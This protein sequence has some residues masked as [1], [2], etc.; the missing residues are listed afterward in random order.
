MQEATKVHV[1]NFDASTTRTASVLIATATSATWLQAVR[2]DYDVT[3]IDQ[4]EQIADALFETRYQLM[5]LD[6]KLVMDE[7]S[8]QL[9]AEIKRRFPS[10]VLCILTDNLA[11]DYIDRLLDT[12]ASDVL[13][14][15]ID[16]E[17]LLRH[18]RVLQRQQAESQQAADHMQQMHLIGLMAREL[19]GTEHPEMLVLE[20]IKILCNNFDLSGVVI[21]IE[22]GDRHHIYAG[23]DE[24]SEPHEVFDSY[25][26]LHN[27]DPLNQVLISGSA[28][29]LNAL[30]RTPF[31]AP[32]PPLQA[33][34]SAVVVPLTYADRP[35]GALALLRDETGFSKADLVPFE[36]FA[37]HLAL[38]YHNISYYHMQEARSRSTRQVLKAWQRLSGH[39]ELDTVLQEMLT[40]IGE[41]P[42]VKHAGLWLFDPRT[43]D[44]RIIT[45]ATR[46]V[47]ADEIQ[48]AYDNGHLQDFLSDTRLSPRP[49]VIGRRTRDPL[50]KLGQLMENNQLL[51]VPIAG[52]IMM[53][54]LIVSS[55]GKHAFSVEET[56]LIEGLAHAASQT[57]ERNT[58]IEEIQL[59]AGRMNAIVSSIHDGVFFIGDNDLVVYCNPQFAELTSI[60][61]AAVVGKPAGNLFGKLADK[62]TTDRDDILHAIQDALD[63]LEAGEY[64][65]IVEVHIDTLNTDIAIEFTRVEQPS[66]G[67]ASRVG[68]V[69]RIHD[70]SDPTAAAHN[71]HEPLLDML[72]DYINLP[73]LQMRES[74]MTLAANHDR[75]RGYSRARLIQQ[76]ASR[77]E[78]AGTLWTHFMQLYDLRR[79]PAAIVRDVFQPHDALNSALMESADLRQIERPVDYHAQPPYTTIR[80]DERLF[81]QAI[82]NLLLG[83]SHLNSEGDVLDV[84][85]TRENGNCQIVIRDRDSVPAYLALPDV[86]AQ[87]QR[88][89]DDLDDS[90]LDYLHFFLAAETIET[91]GGT[92]DIDVHP[93]SG[94]QIEV[95]FAAAESGLEHPV[96]SAA[97]PRESSGASAKH[98]TP[99]RLR[100]AVLEASSRLLSSHYGYLQA[101]GH[102]I[103]SERSVRDILMTMSAARLDLIV[104]ESDNPSPRLA[105]ACE[106]IREESDVPVIIVA[107]HDTRP[108]FMEAIEKGADAYL[109][110]PVSPREMALHLK[111]FARRR[112]IGTVLQ[113]PLQ[114]GDLYIDF[115]RR[116]VFLKNTQLDLTAK[117]Y[118][119]LCELG[120]REG[121]VLSHQELLSQVWGTEYRDEVQY[122]W[123]NVSR[124]RK[125]LEPKKDS[126]RYLQTEKG[127]GYRLCDP[128]ED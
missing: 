29:M 13:P 94:L 5:I 21:A 116:R 28:R 24:T 75:L 99:S 27:Y 65:P 83:V 74:V 45:R 85:V 104:L 106:R 52:A 103:M 67:T 71:P 107:D 59:Q 40:M 95:R 26:T 39:F 115:S 42:A 88:H 41:I 127:V 108:L 60:E 110:L 91:L 114:L 69:R 58:F 1:V 109:V 128:N 89:S 7:D 3:V 50:Q 119:I 44:K 62:A 112:E 46:P 53:G 37:G 20:T 124:L 87:M 82:T 4:T 15:D 57:I 30:E 25:M 47:L 100:I 2:G 102:S 98:T 76:L 55:T 38:A 101:E 61:P 97:K 31:Y 12:G 93:A 63:D 9:I 125:K 92:L 16:S 78:E 64:Y 122:L 72:V 121:Q 81:Q 79:Q 11:N 84:Q 80:T 19:H 51:L 70:R 22:E 18:L 17:T 113:P 120:K 86:I 33:A 105:N 66:D 123:V 117:E 90:S 43:D 36:L 8:F 126:P 111:T 32:V 77:V 10:L 48:T 118:A 35:L 73:Y 14:V 49:L 23:D 34:Q 68:L 54:T 96:S 6:D 56:S